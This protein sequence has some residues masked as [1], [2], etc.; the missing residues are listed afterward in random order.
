MN[1]SSLLAARAAEGRPVR[2]GLIGAGKFGSMVLAQAQRIPGY[3]MVAVADLN[4][5]KARESLARVGW[6][7]SATARRA[8]ARRCKNGTTFVT[9]SVDALLACEEIECVIE[10]TGHPLAGTRHA[11]KAIDAGKHLVMVNVEADVMVGPILAEK[12]RGEGPDLFDGLWRPAGAD[13][14]AGRLGARHRLRG[15]GGRQGHEL[16]AALPL[17]DAGYRLELL[18]LDRGGGRQRATSIRRC[19]TPS[20]TAPRRR[21]R[22]RRSPTAP[23]STARMTASPSRRPACTTWPGCSVRWPTAAAWRSPASSTSP[24]ARSRTAARCSTTSATA[25][26]SPSRRTTSTRRPASSSTAC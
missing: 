22:W 18:R 24:P 20:P 2:V 16:R 11:L 6:P 7:K 25:S 21:S 3:H 15:D 10:A 5:G 12:A 17:F 8:P 4:V 26:S 9:D 19:T 23:A 13:L 14:R 1:L